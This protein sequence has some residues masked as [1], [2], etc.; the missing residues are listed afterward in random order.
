MLGR[1]RLRWL[2]GWI[3]DLAER[4]GSNSHTGGTNRNTVADWGVVACLD[5]RVV[6]DG[7]RGLGSDRSRLSQTPPRL[8]YP[9]LPAHPKR[10]IAIQEAG[11]P[12]DSSATPSRDPRVEAAISHWGLRFVANGVPF[13]DFH[14]VAGSVTHWDD[15]CNAWG[16]R[17]DVQNAL[18]ET[19]IA[20]G[21]PS[22][23]ARCS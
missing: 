19:A 21:Q 8:R 9:I 20:G 2:T 3:P 11:I 16:A 1:Q 14:E 5:E 4:S 10:P 18:G 6:G 7:H 22:C 15:W 17:G 23:A 13:S 12:A